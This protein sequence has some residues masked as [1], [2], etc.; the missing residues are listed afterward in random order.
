MMPTFWTLTSGIATEYRFTILS[1]ISSFATGEKEINF[2][3][4]DRWF[5]NQCRGHW[6]SKHRLSTLPPVWQHELQRQ[7]VPKRMAQAMTQRSCN[8]WP[9]N[10]LDKTMIYFMIKNFLIII[11][12]IKI[13]FTVYVFLILSTKQNIVEDYFNVKIHNYGILKLCGKYTE[14]HAIIE[15]KEWT[16]SMKQL[17]LRSNAKKINLEWPHPGN[18][19]SRLRAM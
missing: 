4:F 5:H 9:R 2:C 1:T 14:Q 17:F 11:V 12:H 15:F 3:K 18:R 16:F 13:F 8:F 10:G 7:R 6:C 19:K